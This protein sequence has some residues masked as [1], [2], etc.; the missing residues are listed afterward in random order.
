M[1]DNNNNETLVNKAVI[2]D[3][4]NYKNEVINKIDN[5]DKNTINT[6]MKDP[7]HIQL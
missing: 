3:I 6:C 7:L 4:D 2:I 1:I 5:I